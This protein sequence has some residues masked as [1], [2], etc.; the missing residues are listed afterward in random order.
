MTPF[1]RLLAI[2]IKPLVMV[3][4]IGVIVVSFLY[5]DRPIA[6]YLHG[7]DLRNNLSCLN[8]FTMLGLSPLYLIP[9]FLLALFFRYI[10]HNRT[11][12][13]RTW[14]LWLCVLFPTIICLILKMLLGR[15]RP[16]LLFG[17]S[18]QYGFYGWHTDASYWSFPSGHTTTAMGLVFGLCVLFPRFFYMFISLGLFLVS[19]R[20]LLTHHYL[21]DVMSAAYLAL[22]EVGLLLWWFKRKNLL[23][24]G[25]SL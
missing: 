13:V 23:I 9:L 3:S 4:C 22:L 21:S 2:M 7:V 6:H 25:C 14:F 18:Q 24:Q 8:W 1:E 10:R 11:W 15:A 16:D 17:S 20:I 5:F 19:S 12:E